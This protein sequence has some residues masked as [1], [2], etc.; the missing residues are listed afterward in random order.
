MFGLKPPA[1][2]SDS[3]ESRL[4]GFHNSLNFARQTDHGFPLTIDLDRARLQSH[5]DFGHSPVYGF[6]AL[7]LNQ[8][9]TAG[10]VAHK[11][12]PFKISTANGCF[13]LT[14]LEVAY[15]SQASSLMEKAH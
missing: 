6:S 2:H 7:G 12:Q 14:A 11:S 3:T 4:S 8:P 13:N 10:F 1:P 5:S 15:V 9:R